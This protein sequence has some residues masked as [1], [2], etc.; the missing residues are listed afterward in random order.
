[1]GN[2]FAKKGGAAEPTQS[3]KPVAVLERDEAILKLKVQRDKL[4]KMK[5]KIILTL[6][7]ETEIAKNLYKNKK[8]EE[9][10]AVLRKKKYQE[11]LLDSTEA[12][13]TNIEQLV[14]NIEEAAINKQVLDGLA[15]GNAALKEIQN[16]MSIDDV[17]DVMDGLK[18]GIEY[19]NEI[20][21]LVGESLS[22]QDEDDLQAQFRAFFEGDGVQDGVDGSEIP[23]APQGEGVIPDA[24][25]HTPEAADA[26][27]A[28][29]TK[30]E[31]VAAT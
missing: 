15:A 27:E 28:T 10:K 23:D 25:T 1:M 3:A 24:A 30:R 12:Q 2:L 16:T 5:K 8:K 18:D 13:V 21:E 9:A 4:K 6:E 31:P 29:A 14:S 20:Q 26:A 11:K 17:Q 22:Q 19:A 7:K